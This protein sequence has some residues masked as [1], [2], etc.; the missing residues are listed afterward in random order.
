MELFEFGTYTWIIF[1]FYLLH[2]LIS[3][4][5]TFTDILSK[6]SAFPE[7]SLLMK[8]HMLLNLLLLFL[9]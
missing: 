5:A 1:L 2:N 4:Q 9:L 6:L 3:T 7:M 8:N